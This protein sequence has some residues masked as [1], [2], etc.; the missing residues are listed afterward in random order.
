LPGVGRWKRGELSRSTSP[1]H[2]VE[3]LIVLW[4]AL[5][6]SVTNLWLHA[7]GEVGISPLAERSVPDVLQDLFTTRPE[8]K[9]PGVSQP[10]G[11]LPASKPSLGRLT[12]LPAVFRKTTP[13]SLDDLKAIE[14][15]VQAIAPRLS[16]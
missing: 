12:N 13:A 3:A 16:P 10:G 6:L 5:M 11:A 8:E 14:R 2:H 15:H 9:P 7:D 4:T 1:R